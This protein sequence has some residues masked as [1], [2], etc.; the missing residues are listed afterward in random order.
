VPG[1]KRLEK[2]V[3]GMTDL[4]PCA[5]QTVRVIDFPRARL[6]LAVSQAGAAYSTGAAETVSAANTAANTAAQT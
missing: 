3:I 1:L 2:E 6:I 5:L 4:S